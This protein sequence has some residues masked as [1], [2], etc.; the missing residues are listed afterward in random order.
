MHF[1]S[2]TP[3]PFDDK[4]AVNSEGYVPYEQE[5]RSYDNERVP[6]HRPVP[7]NH[8]QIGGSSESNGNDRKRESDPIIENMLRKPVDVVPIVGRAVDPES[9]INEG[10]QPVDV[11]PLDERAVDPESFIYEGRQSVDVVPMDERAVDPEVPDDLHKP[12]DIV[13]IVGRA[14]DPEVPDDIDEKPG[15]CCADCRACSGCRSVC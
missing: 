4:R 15:R 7:Q 5:T 10:R 1:P 12:V 6:L 14:V 9:F 2:Q 8:D 13:P 11:V 3:W